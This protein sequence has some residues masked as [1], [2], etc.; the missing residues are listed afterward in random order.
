VA[1]LEACRRIGRSSAKSKTSRRGWLITSAENGSEDVEV[2]EAVAVP[3]DAPE[4]EPEV[5]VDPLDD[6]EGSGA[7]DAILRP[8]TRSA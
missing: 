3:G 1:L 2:R 8:Y 7:V 5:G 4:P 6:V